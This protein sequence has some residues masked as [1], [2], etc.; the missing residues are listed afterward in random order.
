MSSAYNK[1]SRLK[2]YFGGLLAS[3]P[4]G[5]LRNAGLP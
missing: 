2:V 1:H 4:H 5:A 3:S